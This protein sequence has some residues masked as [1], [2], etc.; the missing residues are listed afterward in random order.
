MEKYVVMI[1]Q[2]RPKNNVYNSALH[3]RTYSRQW[4]VEELKQAKSR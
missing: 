4:Q 2:K 1:E 3:K